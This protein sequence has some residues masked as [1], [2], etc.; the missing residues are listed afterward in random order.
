MMKFIGKYSYHI[1]H[2]YR[3]A[4]GCVKIQELETR[5]SELTKEKDQLNKVIEEKDNDIMKVKHH[6]IKGS[7][8]FLILF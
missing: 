2:F 1:Y 8:I 6:K 4:V 7:Y 5:I 3:M